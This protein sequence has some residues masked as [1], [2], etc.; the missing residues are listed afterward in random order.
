MQI[1]TSILQTNCYSVFIDFIGFD[2]AADK[3]RNVT[4]ISVTIITDKNAEKNTH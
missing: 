1:L 3:Q 2:N 4:T